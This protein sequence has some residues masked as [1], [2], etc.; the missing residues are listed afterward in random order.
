MK[1]NCFAYSPKKGCKALGGDHGCGYGCPFYKNTAAHEAGVE[2][3]H[4][5]LATLPEYHQRAI[6]EKYHEG[7]RPWLETTRKAV[8]V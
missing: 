1:T 8:G 4:R 5:R 6:A 2:R 3:A 7:K